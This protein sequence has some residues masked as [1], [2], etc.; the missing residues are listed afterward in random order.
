MA[1]LSHVLGRLSHK[2]KREYRPTS[3]DFSKDLILRDPQQHISNIAMQGKVYWQKKNPF[4][5]FLQFH[6]LDYSFS[7]QLMLGFTIIKYLIAFCVYM[8]FD[9]MPI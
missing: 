6:M 3:M 7:S 5:L 4:W 9:L 8:G 1:S 2:E